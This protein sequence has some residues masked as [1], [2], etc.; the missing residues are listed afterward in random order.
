[1]LWPYYLKMNLLSTLSLHLWLSWQVNAVCIIY[2]NTIYSYVTF[3]FC[4][5][6][7]GWF[8]L[9]LAIFPLFK[10]VW[11]FS[12]L[13]SV[14]KMELTLNIFPLDNLERK[15]E[16]ERKKGKR[17][18]LTTFTFASWNSLHLFRNT[19]FTCSWDTTVSWFSLYHGGCSL[20]VSLVRALYISLTSEF[21]AQG[22]IPWSLFPHW[23]PLWSP[24]LLLCHTSITPG[25]L[26]SSGLAPDVLSIWNLSDN[27]RFT[28]F[29]HFKTH[30]WIKSS[31]YPPPLRG[32]LIFFWNRIPLS[33]S[34]PH[35][36][37][38]FSELKQSEFRLLPESY[39]C[40]SA[41]WIYW[42]E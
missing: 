15:K 30:S 22:C 23:T 39:I 38:N 1:M 8:S 25:T 16:M 41:I 31:A 11:G 34:S 19:L 4:F 42:Q 36:D 10:K 29:L 6:E 21:S 14:I 40:I 13:Q 20:L 3:Y 18:M 33:V 27:P 7:Q 24:Q 37:F 28:P 9:L 26:L 2:S 12:C 17:E 32:S 35:L 5:H